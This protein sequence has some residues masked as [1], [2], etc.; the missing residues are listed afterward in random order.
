MKMLFSH[1]HAGKIILL[2][3]DFSLLLFFN[4]DGARL[5]EKMPFFLLFVS[6]PAKR[7]EKIILSS[8][9][10]G[11]LSR[12]CDKSGDMN[13]SLRYLFSFDSAHKGQKK[14]VLRLR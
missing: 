14:R 12:E 13:R 1:F 2:E 11:S 4:N 7:S 9:K 6:S 5:I 10:L 8:L 3:S